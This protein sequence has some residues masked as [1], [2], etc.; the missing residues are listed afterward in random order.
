MTT[1]R[2]P[3]HRL[4]AEARIL[5][6]PA[7]A[8]RALTR[9][10]G[11]SGWVLARRP[12]LLAFVFGCTLSIQASGALNA[13]TILDGAISF[14]FVPL[15]EIAALAIVYQRAPRS[16]PFARAVDIFFAANAPWLFFMVTFNALRLF[17][18]TR[19]ATAT[20]LVVFIATAS[21]L[22]GTAL[23]SVFI[24]LHYFKIVLPRQD[25]RE[26]RDLAVERAVAW[27]AILLYFFGLAIWPEIVGRMRPV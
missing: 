17:E 12:L 4:S 25:G 1:S 5:L 27:G 14:A 24:D 16:I 22:A 11:G 3:Q 18:T 15:F 6:N 2:S 13:R 8:F 20:P 9:D 10:A 21:A 7:E 19:Q 23:W 26:R